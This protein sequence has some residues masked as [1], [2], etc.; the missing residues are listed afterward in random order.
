M[1]FRSP[2][3]TIV[4]LAAGLAF[5][6]G[7]AA[8]ER[9]WHHALSLVGTSKYPPG[10]EHFKWTNPAAPKGG[11][12][13]IHSIGT[14]DSLN[15]FPIKG[16]AAAAL[17][18]IYQSLLETSPDEP[19]TEYGLIAEAV[20]YPDDFSSVT[21]RLRPEAR[22]HDG[23]PIK[24]EDVIFSLEAIKKVSPNWNFYYKN[25]VRAEK[26]GSHEVTFH[27]DVKG[28]RELPQIVGQ[29][30]VLPKH[31][32]TGTGADGKPRDLA[33]TT[34]EPPL[35]SGPYR[36]GD[37]KPG[38]S[39]TYER[40]DDYWAAK[41]P[42]Q[43]GMWNF[44]K[45]RIEYFR[46]ATVAFEAF[47]A[48]QLDW[49]QETSSKNWATAYDFTAVKEGRVIKE[50]IPLKRPAPMQAF[51]LNTRLKKY[52][53]PRVRRAFNLAYDFEWS[54]KNLFYG[55]YKRVGSYF[56]NTELA[57]KGLP[58]GREK[59]ILEALRKEFPDHVP[60]EALTRE[61]TNPVNADRDAFRK[62]LRQASRL[63]RAAG[64]VVRDGVRVNAKTGEVLE[65]EFLIVSP[66][67]ERVI[68][69]YIQ[70]LKRLGIRAKL[71][72]IDSS[73]Y[74]ARLDS[75]DFDIIV[76]VFPQSE[77]PGNEQRDFW[78]SAAADKHG[79]RN[80]IGIKNPA[81]D[82]LIDMI[83]FA[84][85]REELV[86][87]TRALDR[88]LLWHHFVVP[89]WFSPNARIAYWNKFSR[90]DPLP[91]QAVAFTR[92]WWMDAAKARALEAAVQ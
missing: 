9:T 27:F 82:K 13:R 75:F 2:F 3:W 8:G 58:Q 67:F 83:I 24:P 53:D 17:G 48:G 36:I 59:A 66:A 74:R 16:N 52:S 7:A 92:V 88:V 65:A 56:E 46:D 76:G 38:R 21:F 40:V 71:R 54:N 10:F 4:I 79:S 25:V 12:V 64:W 69:P 77:S 23:E 28:N 5:H 90:P 43:K 47:K 31:Y 50:E 6:A 32:W 81:I 85:D 49:F 87:L 57:A 80:L 89:Q 70:N 14:F 39:I 84:R 86:T 22:F 37:V 51:V 62:H 55:Q 33:K 61:Y 73:Q 42:V 45:L 78:G 72:L 26:T 30:T 1:S 44:D 34:L 41:L 91:A 60:E 63:L 15:Q 68:L 29:L 20:S 18:L 35:G 19:S 11:L